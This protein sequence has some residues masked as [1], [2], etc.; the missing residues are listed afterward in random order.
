MRIDVS[1]LFLFAT[2]TTQYSTAGE[3]E[4]EGGLSGPWAWSTAP[5]WACEG[6]LERCRKRPQLIERL[7][8]MFIRLELS[9]RSLTTRGEPAQCQANARGSYFGVMAVLAGTVR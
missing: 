9:C 3:G 7:L 4:G 8:S 6:Y 1:L 5:W 2:C